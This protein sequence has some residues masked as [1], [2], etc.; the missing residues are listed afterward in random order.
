MSQ[1]KQFQ[2]GA[3]LWGVLIGLGLALAIAACAQGSR[4]PVAAGPMGD[5]DRR[6][7]EITKFS[8]EIREWRKDKGM[9][10]DPTI[11]LTRRPDIIQNSVA[12]IRQ[13]PTEEAPP[14]TE[15][16]TEVC[17]LKDDICDNAESICRIA[18]QLG[19]DAWARGKCNSAKAS[20]KEATEKCCGC[21]ADEK[22][23]ASQ[24]G[25]G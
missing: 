25:G 8:N 17:T 4:A 5:V 15:E 6:K 22:P 7:Q 21:R 16:C 20:C 14:K 3:A 24:P 12:K 19:D 10:P 11:D 1:M 23:A 13:C 2:L 9:S 18:D